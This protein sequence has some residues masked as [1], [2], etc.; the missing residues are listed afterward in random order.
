[1]IIVLRD[2]QDK[3]RFRT[4][5]R[6]ALPGRGGGP[7]THRRSTLSDAQLPNGTFGGSGTGRILGALSQPQ[8]LSERRRHTNCGLRKGPSN[9]PPQQRS[10]PVP[11]RKSTRLNS[12]HVA[13]SYAVF[14]LKKKTT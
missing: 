11:D 14:C 3:T 8:P 6:E 12:S 4:N 5:S 2:N 7:S 13:I 9:T 1:M 10:R